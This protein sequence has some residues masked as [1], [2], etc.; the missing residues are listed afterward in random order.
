MAS[1]FHMKSSYAPGESKDE[2]FTDTIE[3]LSFS[4]GGYQPSAGSYVG[5]SNTG[6][7]S[8]GTFA[9]S[10][11]LDK[12]YPKFLQGLTKGG[13]I[14]DLT[15]TA[16]KAVGTTTTFITTKL[17]NPIVA[18]LYVTGEDDGSGSGS[19]PVVH[20]EFAYSAYEV[21]YVPTD[22]AGKAQGNIKAGYD[23]STNKTS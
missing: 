18:K 16:S 14:G 4:H 23:L 9:I 21:T 19:R 10:Y 17:S 8:M 6:R 5:G 20:A 1:D 15:F 7:V 3:C 12:S 22:S 11:N 2:G 13:S